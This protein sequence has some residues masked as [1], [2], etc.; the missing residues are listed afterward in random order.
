MRVSINVEFDVPAIM[1]DG[2]ILYSNIFRPVEE[3]KFPVLI[4][5]TPYG[6]DYMT[7]F[8]FLDM[9]RLAKNGF[10]VVAQDVRGRGSSHGKWELF[11]NE[12]NDG[13]DSV[14]WAAKLPG[15]NGN[16]GMWGF[17][18]LGYAQWI[19]AAL[20]PPHLKAIMPVFTWA[21]ARNGLYWRGGAL[22]LGLLLNLS[23]PSLGLEIIFKQYGDSPE[24]LQENIN[25]FV[26]EVD[27][28]RKSGFSSLPLNELSPIVNTGL[29]IS[30][31]EKLIENQNGEMY[32][33]LPYSFYK[34]YEKVTIP[35]YNIAGWYDI[36]SQD[37]INNYSDHINV[38][39]TEEAKHSRLMIGPWSHLNF[40]NVIGDTDFGMGSSMSFI[41]SEMDHVALATKW[42]EYWLKGIE[43]GVLDEPPVKVFVT[44]KNKWQ[45]EDEWP[46]SRSKI[47]TF[48]LHSEG[49][50]SKIQP[51]LEKSY[52]CYY[53]DPENPTPTVGGAQ[54]IHPGITPGV[55]DQQIIG[56]RDDVLS[57]NSQ[58][59]KSDMGVLG[60][61][62]VS[63]WAASSAIDTD[64]VARLI[65]VSPNGFAHNLTDG[66]IRARYRNLNNNDFLDPEIPVEFTID[67]WSIGHVF[68]K[69]HQIRLDITSSN[70]P[71]WDRNLNTG[72]DFGFGEHWIVAKQFIYHD[73]KHPSKL[74]LPVAN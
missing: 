40:T 45:S 16:V 51:S 18:Y 1:R 5:R 72:D 53:Y 50:L 47:N 68:L 10:I 15:S 11:V 22:E 29:G 23:L 2:T 12:G 31:L 8:P 26:N 35:A 69:G 44:G 25:N 34:N 56:Q 74:L 58:P 30:E 65:D 7:G 36:F 70:F 71:R 3:G 43:N 27:N 67:L 41:D 24:K 39:N 42:F 66:I 14:E 28:L 55:K 46:P 20:N 52:D 17:S 37:T 21:N 49:E 33:D 9:V 54:H 60:T 38:A 32:D 13:Y 63:L 61:V 73:K 48:F 59:L 62:E 4:T 57:F 6:K 19:T 64:F